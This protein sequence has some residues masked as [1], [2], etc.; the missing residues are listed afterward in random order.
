M[1]SARL[2][3]TYGEPILILCRL[4][5]LHQ[6]LHEPC[7]FLEMKCVKINISHW[8]LSSIHPVAVSFKVDMHAI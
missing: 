4:N 8:K 5:C 1:A 6:N 3:I 7:L 2:A